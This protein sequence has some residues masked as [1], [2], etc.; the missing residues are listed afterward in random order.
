MESSSI[1]PRVTNSAVGAAGD[2][3]RL[4]SR[5]PR[6]ENGILLKGSGRGPTCSAL[7]CHNPHEPKFKPLKPE[8]APSVN[9]L[10]K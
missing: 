7:S 6:E 3:Q 8:P 4:E 9:E 10:R 2:L 5:H 1:S